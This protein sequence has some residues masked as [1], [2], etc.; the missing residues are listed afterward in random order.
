MDGGNEREYRATVR[1]VA[2]KYGVSE[3]TV[4]AWLASDNPPPNRRVGGVWRFNLE[5]V[6]EWASRGGR[7]TEEPAEK[8]AA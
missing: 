5:E 7:P 2:R 8:G 4:Y 6:D 1:D 3:N